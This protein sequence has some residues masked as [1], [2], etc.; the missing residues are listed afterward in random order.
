MQTAHTAFRRGTAAGPSLPKLHL[1]PFNPGTTQL[2]ACLSSEQSSSDRWCSPCSEPSCRGGP[3]PW[4]RL[5]DHRQWPRSLA[6]RLCD[7]SYLHREG[8]TG[9][10][11]SWDGSAP[12]C[13]T[14]ACVQWGGR[15]APWLR[16]SEA[17]H[18]LHSE[19]FPDSDSFR[20]FFFYFFLFVFF[21]FG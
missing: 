21:S 18:C 3:I 2:A 16:T 12:R 10:R 7:S 14:S 20:L 9:R 5:H 15:A 4:A 17:F 8:A 11:M 13:P 1:I 19:D 6:V